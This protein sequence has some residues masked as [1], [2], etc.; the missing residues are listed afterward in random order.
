MR[1]RSMMLDVGAATDGGGQWLRI[2]G[3]GGA[4]LGNFNAAAGCSFSSVQVKGTFQVCLLLT[5]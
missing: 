3:W 5:G 2:G 1:R 4:F